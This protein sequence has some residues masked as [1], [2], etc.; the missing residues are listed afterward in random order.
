LKTQKQDFS[1]L[2]AK[3]P[4][5][6][7]DSGVGGLTV[8]KEIKR[9]L[10]QED[11]IYFGDTKHL[12]YGEKSREAIVGYSTKITQFLLEKNC[13]AVVIACNSAT[14]NALKEVLELVNDRVPVIDVINPVAEKVSY[15]IHNNVGVIATKATVNSGLYKKSIRKH[16]KFIKVD[17][18]ATPLLVPAIEEGFR[19]HPITHSIIYNY[20]SNSKLK[21]IETLI[22]GCTHYPLLLNEIKQYYGNRVRVIDSP[23]IVANQLKMILEKHHLLNGDNPK[24]SYQFYLSDITKNFEKISKKFFGKTI[25]LELKVL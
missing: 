22:L 9:L 2:S 13:K 4:I 16:N 25:D 12:P 5:G 6:I 1:H 18:L 21:N 11:L 24:P 14:A 17:E 10:P 7:F 15:E 3:Q 19:N 8:A 20:L 23:S